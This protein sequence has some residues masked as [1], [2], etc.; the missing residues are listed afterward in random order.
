ML[1]DY[2]API[3][4]DA[5]NAARL[6]FDVGVARAEAATVA[7]CVEAKGFPGAESLRVDEARFF[8]SGIVA[9]LPALNR[10]A[11]HGFTNPSLPVTP[12]YD[13]AFSCSEEDA[14][15]ATRWERDAE[16]LRSES[17]L[18]EEVPAAIDATESTPV[19]AE[20]VSCMTAAGAPPDLLDRVA[21]REQ[22][23]IEDGGE[24]RSHGFEAFLYEWASDDSGPHPDDPDYAVPEEVRTFVRC[25]TPFFAEVERALAGPRAAFVDEHRDEL[26]QLQREFEALDVEGD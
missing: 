8:A 5:W 13:A 25:T 21:A 3:N 12:E 23:M 26:L 2:V 10:L 4:G 19:W 16:N 20:A 1:L 11:E 15:A 18:S 7:E 6:R 9:N 22:R 14:S 24:P 17:F